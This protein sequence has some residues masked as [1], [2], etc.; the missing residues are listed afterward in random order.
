MTNTDAFSVI[1]RHQGSV[2]VD[3][4]AVARDLGLIVHPLP[5]GPNVS[6]KLLRS[7]RAPAGFEIQVD[8]AESRRRQRFTVAHELAHYVLHSDLINS[9]I[10]DN[11]MYRSHLSDQYEVQANRLAADILMPFSTIRRLYNVNLSPDE[12]V[13]GLA[14]AFD[15][16]REAMKIRLSYTPGL[17]RDHAFV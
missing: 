2:P 6:G 13:A 4:E 11:Q 12:N 16:S 14:E 9:G 8:E 3:V 7:E 1:Q 10:V 15:V 5:L 17:E